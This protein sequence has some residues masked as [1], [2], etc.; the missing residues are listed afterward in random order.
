MIDGTDVRQRNA[1]VGKF[2][3]I[4]TRIDLSQAWVVGEYSTLREARA[5][6]DNA[7]SLDVN[8][9]IHSDSSR[10]L[11]TKKGVVDA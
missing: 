5:I 1:Q 8:Y 4:A 6:V 2:R 10:V 7:S 11:Y 3:I 9:Y